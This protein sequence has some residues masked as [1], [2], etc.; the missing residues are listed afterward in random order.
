MSTQDRD[1]DAADRVRHLIAN[2][3]DV[4]MGGRF[5]TMTRVARRMIG[6]AVLYER[7]YHHQIDLALLESSESVEH[8]TDLDRRTAAQ[9]VAD[10]QARL[11]SLEGRIT[12]VAGRIT[13]QSARLGEMT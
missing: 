2:G 9:E 6:R 13:D 8:K 12:E 1:Q 5:G 3:P 4:N 7:H 11:A 10:L